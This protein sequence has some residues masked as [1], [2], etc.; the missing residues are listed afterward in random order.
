MN[1]MAR[2]ACTPAAFERLYQGKWDPWDFR[3]ST[4]ERNRYQ[5]TLDALDRSRYQFAFEPGCSIGEL[6][7]LLAPLCADLLATDVSRTAV[8]RARK[9]CAMFSH[10]RFECDDLRRVTFNIAPDLIVLSEIAYYF[11]ATE[12]AELAH[13][14]YAQLSAGG[15]L[16][17]VHWLG[18]SADH[19]LHGDEA[20]EV[21][22]ETLPRRCQTGARHTRFRIDRW[23]RA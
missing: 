12:L 21:L 18:K 6:T 10:V 17:A 9:R 5:A 22:L 23:T 14:L 3:T 2:E 15:T 13:R 8:E 20:H 11:D 7:A 4:Y 1:P 19:I 16:I